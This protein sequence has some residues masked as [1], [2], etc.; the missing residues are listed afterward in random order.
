[1]ELKLESLADFE[2]YYLTVEERLHT[3]SDPLR[4]H[5]KAWK[6]ESVLKLSVTDEGHG[7]SFPDAPEDGA[8]PDRFVGRGLYIIQSLAERAW[9]GHDRRTLNMIFTL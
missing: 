1:M 8:P 5:I 9:V 6:K 3:Q 2:A 7:F 4:I